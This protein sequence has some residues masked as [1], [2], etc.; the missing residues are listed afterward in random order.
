MIEYK[1]HYALLSN[2]CLNLTDACNY[3]CKYCFVEQNPH[4]M[5]L[6]TAKSAVD[7]ILSNYYKKKELFPDNKNIDCSIAFF[8]G[9]PTLMWDSIIVPLTNYIR[10][11]NF[12]INLSM[13]SNGSLLNEE[14]IAFMKKNKI[15]LLLSMDGDRLTQEFNRP[16]LNE[17]LSS[18]DLTSKN[19]PYILQAFPQTTF[20]ATIFA[21]TAKYTFD[22]YLYA[23]NQGF[24]NIYL[25]PDSRHIWSEQ[26]KKELH[27][28]LNE[29]Y[30]FLSGCFSKNIMPPIKFKP[31]ERSFH[32]ILNHDLKVVRNS[33]S[34]DWTHPI[35]RCGL[36]TSLGSIGYDGSIYGCQEQTSQ[37]PKSIF[38]IGNIFNGGIDKNKHLQLLEEFH[39]EKRNTCE[40]SQL[41]EDCLLKNDCRDFCCPSTGYDLFHE[42]HKDAEIHC[43]WNRWIF[44]NSIYMMKKYVAENNQTFKKYLYEVCDFKK[45]FREEVS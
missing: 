41:C 25:L 34:N 15:G 35:M 1:E 32:S 45:V 6:D 2:I 27:N 17:N 9:E 43:L 10:E 16:C 19:I 21:P 5:T 39:T 14:R 20:R 4:Y 40:N 24:K 28:E 12:P 22:N 38:Y 36:G 44:E 8:G 31:I 33:F 13:T 18:F 29:I 11:N 30:S 7:F 37:G 26:E 3:G 42:F 23:I